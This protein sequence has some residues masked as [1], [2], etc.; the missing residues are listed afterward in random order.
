MDD[1]QIRIF[2]IRH[3]GPGCA[4]SLVR[5]FEEWQ[6]DALLIEGPPEGEGVLPLAVDQTMVPPVALLV[7]SE[8]DVQ[9]AAFYPFAAFSP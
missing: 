8:E 7:Y 5:A 1:S 2:G 4:R 3:H 9:R 6:P